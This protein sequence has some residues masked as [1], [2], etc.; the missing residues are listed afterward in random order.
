MI[1]FIHDLLF[2]KPWEKDIE[3]FLKKAKPSQ[4]DEYCKTL[5]IS[6]SREVD[7]LKQYWGHAFGV[8]KTYNQYVHYGHGFYSTLFTVPSLKTGDTMLLKTDKG[9]G[10]YVVLHI[11]YERDPRDMFWAYI[12]CIGI[13]HTETK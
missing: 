1:K 3:A 9:V 7:F 11:R 6:P 12:A 13:K 2:K 5:E 4:I 8:D 10:V